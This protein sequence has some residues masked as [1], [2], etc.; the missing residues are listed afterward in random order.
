MSR[1]IKHQVGESYSLSG[2]WILFEKKTYDYI[3]KQLKNQVRKEAIE[4]I[5]YLKY[6]LEAIFKSFLDG[7]LSKGEFL[8][9]FRDFD[10]KLEEMSK[11]E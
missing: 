1:L 11:D 7:N 10:K 8:T 3:V 2:K 4:K 5:N 6:E 9:L